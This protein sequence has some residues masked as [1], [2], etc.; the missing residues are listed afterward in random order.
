MNKKDINYQNINQRIFTVTLFLS[1][2]TFPKCYLL[3]LFYTMPW[4][5]KSWTF[6]EKINWNLCLLKFAESKQ[7]SPPGQ[8][9]YS[10]F[11]GNTTII[12]YN[13]PNYWNYKVVQVYIEYW[14]NALF[15]YNGQFQK[16]NIKFFSPPMFSISG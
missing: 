9:F 13:Q 16:S 10:L 3:R 5:L 4:L 2:F 7:P 8:N 1:D 11:P 6:D 14:Q 12:N 15:T